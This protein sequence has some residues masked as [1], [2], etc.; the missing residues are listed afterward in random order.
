MAIISLAFTLISPP[1][2][3]SNQDITNLK[4][5]AKTVFFFFGVCFIIYILYFTGRYISTLRLMCHMISSCPK[6]TSNMGCL[7]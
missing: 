7:D 2:P 3:S 1:P 5:M 6:L 4:V